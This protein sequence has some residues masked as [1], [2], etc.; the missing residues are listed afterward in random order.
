MT[1]M[2]I[3]VFGAGRGM[4]LATNFML[5]G[6]DIV[7]LCDAR[8]EMLEQFAP[9]LSEGGK[10]YEDFDSFIQHE[11][12]AIILANNFHEHAPM[13]SAAWKRASMYSASASATA[14]WPRVWN[15]SAQQKRA[16]LS[17]SWRRTTRR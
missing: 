4:D 9:Q 6:C 17:S 2:K 3:G 1:K 8:K 11:M 10:T 12:D 15:S 7:A 5:L 14:P 16:T 13:P